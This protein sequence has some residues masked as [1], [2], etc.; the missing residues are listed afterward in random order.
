ML[1]YPIETKLRRRLKQMP[2][3]VVNKTRIIIDQSYK[4]KNRWIFE[5][6][7][8]E[9]SFLCISDGYDIKAIRDF[10]DDGRLEMEERL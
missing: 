1:N 5:M 9:Q 3:N 10:W 6:A 4:N 8:R 7:Y 2:T